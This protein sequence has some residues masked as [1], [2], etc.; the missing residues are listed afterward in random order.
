MPARGL[1]FGQK[2]EGASSVS[3][4]GVGC[5][6]DILCVFWELWWSSLIW[7]LWY[8][9][10][11]SW[12]IPWGCVI[13]WVFGL[14]LKSSSVLT[15]GH[16]THT[17]VLCYMYMGN[18]GQ[19]STSIVTRGYLV[20][21]WGYSRALRKGIWGLFTNKAP[22]FRFLRYPCYAMVDYVIQSS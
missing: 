5:S 19:V 13:T 16:L 9:Q 17:W 22:T 6:S 4:R 1:E 3:P 14:L 12:D 10:V 18:A 21:P 7:V 11:G 20:L 15:H 2:G 8:F